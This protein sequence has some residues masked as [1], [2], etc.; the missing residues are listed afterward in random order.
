MVKKTKPKPTIKRR[1]ARP[2]QSTDN[3]N[4]IWVFD[5]VDRDGH[6]R[7]DPSRVDM[8]CRDI[9]EKV[10]DYS[11]RTWQDIKTETHGRDNKS[12]HHILNVGSLSE[13]ARSRIRHLDLE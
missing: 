12:K 4:Q 10:V 2:S 3:L 11:R 6:F 5:S 7:F 1:S 8:N 9:L 13:K